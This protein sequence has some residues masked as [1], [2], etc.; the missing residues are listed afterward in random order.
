MLLHTHLRFVA[1]IEMLTRRRQRLAAADPLTA[2]DRRVDQLELTR[3]P[4]KVVGPRLMSDGLC[5]GAPCGLIVSCRGRYGICL[6]ALW[7]TA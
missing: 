3:L 6:V 5:P 7:S 2:V 4:E 1:D